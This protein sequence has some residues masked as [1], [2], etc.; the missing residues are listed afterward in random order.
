MK[1]EK[2]RSI[3]PCFEIDLLDNQK[4]WMESYLIKFVE[5]EEL[6]NVHN[7]F[8]VHR[9]RN[10]CNF[11][12]SNI[13]YKNVWRLENWI[14]LDQTQLLLKSLQFHLLN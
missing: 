2:K 3:F 8:C 10:S 14:V 4:G 7:Y 1:K 6:L 9:R 5:A 11:T 12:Q 13:S